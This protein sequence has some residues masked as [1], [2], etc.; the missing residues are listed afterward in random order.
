LEL[1]EK[2]FLENEALEFIGSNWRKYDIVKSLDEMEAT[3]KSDEE[4]LNKL[5]DE[6][7][8]LIRRNRQAPKVP[9]EAHHVGVHTFDGRLDPSTIRILPTDPPLIN[10]NR[11]PRQTNFKDL[12][13]VNLRNLNARDLV[14]ETFNGI[15][16]DDL[17]F[18]ENGKLKV[19]GELV[20]EDS[21]KVQKVDLLN[22]GTVNEVVIKKDILALDSTNLPDNLGFESIVV[23]DVETSA[24]NGIPMSIKILEEISVIDSNNLSSISTKEVELN[25]NLNA[26]TINGISWQE[27][28]KN[29][30]PKHIPSNIDE[31]E[32][33]GNL[34]ITEKGKLAI[35]VLNK[36][37]F[38]DEFVQKS[39]PE[40][41]TILGKKTFL[42]KLGE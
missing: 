11:S 39:G 10:H 4:E 3:V 34:I 41:T 33:L 7:T 16:A 40:E 22:E 14:F 35:N 8:N 36:L 19:P 9:D 32:V 27:F 26:E 20:F 23:E 37:A 12:V 18:I 42:G 17:M 24:I 15:P 38:P 13:D 29:L 31:I 5:N 1:E 30:V 2:V 28:Q 6:L 21:V 25:G